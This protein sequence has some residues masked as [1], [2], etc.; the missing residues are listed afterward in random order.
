VSRLDQL[1]A[2]EREAMVPPARARAANLATLQRAIADGRAPIVDAP[3]FGAPLLAARRGWVKPTL[4]GVLVL[5][6][7]AL[8]VI[9]G[10]R[11]PDEGEPA[12]ATNVVA[13]APVVA[14][15]QTTTAMDRPPHVAVA[16]P[17]IVPDTPAPAIE[18][19]APSKPKATRRGPTAPP[20][21]DFAAELGLLKRAKTAHTAGDRERALA[22]LR[23]QARRFPRGAFVE[24]RRALEAIALCELGRDRGAAAAAAF[25]RDF[26][27]SPQTE[28]VRRACD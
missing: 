12:P 4:L 23:E 3:P 5:G 19:P 18:I 20:R 10:G 26:A 14:P 28:R 6:L 24:E 7:G 15:T 1:I 27:A 16:P 2:A 22:I 8:A 13:D 11:G 25:H 21:D 17:A 9:L